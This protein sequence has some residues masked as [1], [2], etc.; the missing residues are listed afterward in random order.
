MR[1]EIR[2]A[3]QN[4]KPIAIS[5]DWIID[6]FKIAKVIDDSIS[7][8]EWRSEYTL[9]WFKVWDFFTKHWIQIYYFNRIQ[10]QFIL[11]NI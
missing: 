1:D 5:L 9:N 7:I 3:I 11:E 8:D 10:N 4:W 6:F 2:I